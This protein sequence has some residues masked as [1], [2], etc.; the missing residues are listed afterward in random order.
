MADEQ[1]IKFG[2]YRAKEKLEKFCPQLAAILGIDGPI[3]PPGHNGAIP[4]VD[5]FKSMM[6][7]A[8]LADFIE[9]AVGELK[10][11]NATPIKMNLSEDESTS[12]T[13]A[14]TPAKPAAQESWM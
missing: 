14:T 2:M 12:L 9:K 8:S 10:R 13:P 4:F 6:R 3:E 7:L 1:S 11:R 5:Q